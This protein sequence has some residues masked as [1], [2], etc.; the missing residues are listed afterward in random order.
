MGH[1]NLMFLNPIISVCNFLMN[2]G[3]DVICQNPSQIIGTNLQD[4]LEK[5]F[6]MEILITEFFQVFIGIDH[7]SFLKGILGT[8][9]LLQKSLR[10]P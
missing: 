5:G 2:W 1:N 8:R 10:F 4:R 6:S 9:L 3:L 7:F